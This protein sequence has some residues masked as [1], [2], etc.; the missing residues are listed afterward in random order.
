MEEIKF[1]SFYETKYFLL[2][3]YMNNKD[4]NAKE[5]LIEKYPVYEHIDIF[6]KIAEEAYNHFMKTKYCSFSM[7]CDNMFSLIDCTFEGYDDFL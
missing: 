6:I 4:E 2:S 5:K 3:S 1:V 7:E